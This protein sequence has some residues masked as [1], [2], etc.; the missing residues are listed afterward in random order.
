MSPFQLAQRLDCELY[1]T[2]QQYHTQSYILK[3]TCHFCRNPSLGLATKGT[4]AKRSVRECEEEDSHS[5]VSSH[6]GSWSPSGLSNLQRII[7][8]VK[9]PCIKEFFIPLKIYW[10]VDVLNGLAW[11]IQTSITQVM[12]K[13]K[14]M[15]QIGSLTPDHK[16]SGIDSIP[17]R[18]S[19]VRHTVEKLSTR[20]TNLLQTSSRSKVWA[21]NYSLP[22]LWEFQP[23]QFRDSPSRGESQDKK[24]FGCSFCEEVKSILYGGRWWFPPSPGR[25]ESYESEVARGLS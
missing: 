6:F 19:G 22:K 12:A 9:T 23:W 1:T 14:V 16:M 15:S 2:T 18:A 4:Q 8:E 11:P 7:A 17:V 5:Q 13:G 20:A 10:S 24:P 25:G 21:R 3:S